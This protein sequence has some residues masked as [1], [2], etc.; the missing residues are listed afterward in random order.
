[1]HKLLFP[2]LKGTWGYVNFGEESLSLR[3]E[4]SNPLLMPTACGK[5][6]QALHK[7]YSIDYSYGGYMEDRSNLWRGHYMLP[8]YTWHLGIDYT[9]PIGTPVVLPFDAVLVRSI[10]DTDQDGGW[11]GK[12]FFKLDNHI[13]IFA[14]MDRIATRLG[15]C[16]AGDIIGFIADELNNGGWFPHLHVQ[17]VR[18]ADPLLDPL[19]VDGYDR[20]RTGIEHDFPRPDTLMDE[21][22]QNQQNLDAAAE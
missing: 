21:T 14:H 3:K 6:V 22:W 5:W 4:K 1:M 9:V 19:E 20:L 17:A 15:Q 2:S 12:T 8:G 13:I 18:S 10:V 7:K 16:K 11:G